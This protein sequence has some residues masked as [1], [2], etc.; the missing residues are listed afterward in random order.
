MSQSH[1]SSMP[2]GDVSLS[3][4]VFPVLNFSQDVEILLS[5]QDPDETFSYVCISTSDSNIL[6]LVRYTF[7]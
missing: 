1:F 3:L 4:A 5:F 7:A 6:Q 2:P